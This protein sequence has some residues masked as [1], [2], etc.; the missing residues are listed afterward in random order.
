LRYPQESCWSFSLRNAMNRH[1]VPLRPRSDFIDSVATIIKVLKLSLQS[2]IRMISENAL[3]MPAA[4]Y[5]LNRQA[6][7]FGLAE[8]PSRPA[9]QQ[10]H[11]HHRSIHHE[12]PPYRQ[13]RRPREARCHRPPI[14][15]Q[16]LCRGRLGQDQAL[17]SS[18]A[19]GT[20]CQCL[21]ES[22]IRG[23]AGIAHEAGLTTRCTVHVQVA[24]CV[25]L[26]LIRPTP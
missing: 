21:S 4:A 15:A 7:N 17:P 16:R 12:L 14:P 23:L 2:S 26:P 25:C 6:Q 5:R 13:G 24:R 10:L 19:S 1:V 8:T 22:T 11:P 3:T 18:S 9:D 20:H